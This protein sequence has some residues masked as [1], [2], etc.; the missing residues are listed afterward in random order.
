MSSFWIGYG[1]NYIGG[2]GS[3]Q[4]NLA[5]R[6]PT[7]IQGIPAICLAIGI[8]IMPYSPRWLVK[9][10]KDEK[11]I[12]TLSFLR[13][14][15]VDDELVQ[16]EYLEIKAEAL[17]EKRAFAQAFPNLAAKEEGSVWIREVAQYANCFRTKDNFKRVATAWLVMFFQQWSGIDASETIPRFD[18]PRKRVT[19]EYFQSY[20]MQRMSLSVSVCLRSQ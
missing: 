18:L 2:T 1:S 17:F 6:L 9:A 11:A 20:T 14:L 12:K 5:W 16:I 3:T 10:G 7:I 15:P 13:N 4:S 8:W 19:D